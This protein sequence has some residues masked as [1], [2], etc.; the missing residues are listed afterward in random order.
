MRR[1]LLFRQRTS[2]EAQPAVCLSRQRLVMGHDEDGGV[3]LLREVPKQLN[4][5]L[6]RF[7]DRKSVV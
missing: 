6:A 2:G 4:N 5:E 1:S 3:L 7:L